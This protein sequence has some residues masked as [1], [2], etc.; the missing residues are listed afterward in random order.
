[1]P[2]LLDFRRILSRA[3]IYRLFQNMVGTPHAHDTFIGEYVRPHA[4]QRLLDMGCGPGQ[5]AAYLPTVH[6]VGFDA[7]RDYVSAARRSYGTDAGP[8]FVHYAIGDAAPPWDRDFDL[9]TAVFLL[10]HLD[11]DRLIELFEVAER[12]LVPG[13]RLWTID[14]CYVDG[15]SR[16]GRF[17]TSRDRGEHVRD[18]VGYVRLARRVF[19]DVDTHMRHD[20]LRIPLTHLIMGCRTPVH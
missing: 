12:S 5:M 17:I 15:Q 9:V 10:H 6:Y 7:S 13:G 11:D 8:R 20:L 19:G 14:P 3:P 4:E 16:I 1:M 2:S 18:E